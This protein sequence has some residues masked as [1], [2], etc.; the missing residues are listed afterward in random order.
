MASLLCIFK[1]GQRYDW[2]FPNNLQEISASRVM[3][4]MRMSALSSQRI[5]LILRIVAICLCSAATASAEGIASMTAITRENHKKLNHHTLRVEL[6]PQHGVISVHLYIDAEKGREA[7]SCDVE[8]RKEVEKLTPCLV[9]FRAQTHSGS[10]HFQVADELVD[11]I[12]VR[13]RLPA[14]QFQTHDFTI[15][16]GQL[17]K[18]AA[19]DSIDPKK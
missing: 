8:I 17:R 13:Y 1:E 14:N 11:R 18:L 15:A 5:L 3:I 9:R 6:H 10:I 4:H 19:G 7:V 2:I 12:F 16:P